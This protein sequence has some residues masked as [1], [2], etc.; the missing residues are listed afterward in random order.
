MRRQ[1]WPPFLARRPYLTAPNLPRPHQRPDVGQ[2][3]S[4]LDARTQ[5]PNRPVVAR[6]QTETHNRVRVSASSQSKEPSPDRTTRHGWV[7]SH[8]RTREL[9][10]GA[11]I[12]WR[13]CHSAVDALIPPTYFKSPIDSPT[14]NLLTLSGRALRAGDLLTTPLL[15]ERRTPIAPVEFETRQETETVA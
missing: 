7:T 10:R 5:L 8:K 11:S 6:S 4:G 2:I 1:P 13:P 15:L 9:Q 14:T 12:D 3:T